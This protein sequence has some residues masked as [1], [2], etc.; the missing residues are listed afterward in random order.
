MP[1]LPEVQTIVDGLNAAQIVGKRIA[2]ASVYWPKIIALSSPQ[3]FIRHVTDKIIQKIH[4]RAKYIV[5]TLSDG[6]FMIVHL[7]M[8]GRFELERLKAPRNFHVHIIL[9]L[10]DERRLLYHDTRK[11]GRFFLT[12]DLNDVI[13]S[14]GPEPLEANFTA[15]ILANMLKKRK[16]QVKPLLLD[17]NFIAGLGNIYVDE[18]LW[19]SRIHPL[20]AANSLNRNEIK[21]LHRSIRKVLRQGI[22]NSGTTL[23]KGLGNYSGLQRNRGRNSNYLKVFRRTGQV[24]K[25]CSNKVE[26]IVVGQRGTHICSQCQV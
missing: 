15:N 7:R 20:R 8:T 23:G 11:F 16:R 5:F 2:E 9:R 14:L 12:K 4:R 1:E 17:Q 6:N 25:R 19:A 13:G 24:C 22:R 26:R 21:S 10:S 18:A 3:K